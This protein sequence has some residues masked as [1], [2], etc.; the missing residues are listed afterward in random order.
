MSPDPT[1]RDPEA[2]EAPVSGPVADLVD[3]YRSRQDLLHA[4]QREL[5]ALEQQIFEAAERESQQIITNARQRVRTILL[6][7]RRELL[8]LT[9]QVAASRE[10]SRGPAPQFPNVVRA[11]I[12]SA[13]PEIE[14]L[15]AEASALRA[16][17]RQ[18]TPEPDAPAPT[19]AAPPLAI[20]STLPPPLVV[21]M[22]FEH[23][24]EVHDQDDFQSAFSEPISLSMTAGAPG[25]GTQLL[26][27]LGCVVIVAVAG[28]TFWWQRRA[29]QTG[30]RS[31]A[32]LATTSRQ[33]ATANT[34][35]SSAA[36]EAA[37]GPSAAALTRHISIQTR[38]PVW[39]RLN[40]D[41]RAD[42]GRT[43]PAG[44]RRDIT[45]DHVSIRAGDAGAVL[46]SVNGG[47]QEP[48][49]G[50]GVTLTRDFTLNG[51]AKP[52]AASAPAA[53]PAL[54]TA[55]NTATPTSAGRPSP[56]PVTTPS[57]PAPASSAAGPAPQPPVAPV[58]NGNGTPVA[59]GVPAEVEI[60]RAAETWFSAFFRRDQA[61]MTQAGGRTTVIDDQRGP[62]DVPA[63][64][65]NV[66]RTFEQGSVQVVGNSA[67]Y[68][69]RL[70]ETA[71]GGDRFVALVSQ[72]WL[73]SGASWQLLNVR[74]SSESHVREALR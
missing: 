21:E 58:A 40:I 73:R 38:R 37:A 22:P 9:A 64:G 42:A 16:T 53:P 29:P 69:G 34:S 24:T 54:S 63:A 43:V 26:I 10:H 66:R 36:H 25:R 33:Q 27:A 67:M 17:F 48:L 62:S 13:R 30:S 51:R 19:P 32:A 31:P 74:L 8:V 52:A 14:S 61:A 60:M 59:A 20:G 28:M 11:V 23:E 1:K 39:L 15:E 3:T 44:E 4:Q 56:P 49:G 65:L 35:G 71:P 55:L 68:T 5:A 18:L 46:V 41:D 6:E 70:I 7:A 47:A 12:G 50:D 45:A 57:V 72:V 2:S